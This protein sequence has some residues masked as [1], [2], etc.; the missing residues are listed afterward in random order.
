MRVHNTDTLLQ[1]VCF[2]LMASWAAGMDGYQ[3][4]IPGKAASDTHRSRIGADRV[5]DPLL[6][7]PA[8]S[9]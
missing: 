3:A 9:K 7:T 5:K 4:T 6:R 2:C 1:A 8:S